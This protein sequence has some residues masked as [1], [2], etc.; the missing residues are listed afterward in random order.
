[1][2]NLIV[3]NVSIDFLVNFFTNLIAFYVENIFSKSDSLYFSL[4][5][6]EFMLVI[7]ANKTQSNFLFFYSNSLDQL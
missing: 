5:A 1:M 2:K 6:N 3:M 4:G 7:C